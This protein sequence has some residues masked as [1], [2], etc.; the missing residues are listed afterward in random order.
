[1]E[2]FTTSVPFKVISSIVFVNVMKID[3][4]RR[5]GLFAFSIH[6]CVTHLHTQ[7]GVAE[8]FLADMREIV[9][10]IMKNPKAEAGGAV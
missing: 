6:L 9:G 1:M 5:F 10:E 2:P 4:S 3:A 8:R 7:E